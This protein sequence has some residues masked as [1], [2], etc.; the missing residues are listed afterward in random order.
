MK[1]FLSLFVCTLVLALAVSAQSS[2]PVS[3][4]TTVRMTSKSEGIITMTATMQ[5]GWHIYNTTLVE[6]GSY[7][8]TSIDLTES[9]GIK[10]VG[11]P[12]ASAKA[13]T[14]DDKDF[15]LISYWDNKVTFVQKFKLTDK[16]KARVKGKINYMSCNDETC[17]PPKNELIDLPVPA[18]KKG[19]GK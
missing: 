9:T 17:M 16:A 12:K 19:K 8:K 11:A 4:K 7:K 15:G 14:V 13:V 3:W 2:N 5:S 10:L 1:R 6:G 18:Y